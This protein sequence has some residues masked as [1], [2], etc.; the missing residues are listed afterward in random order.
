[1][2]IL[3]GLR[4][5]HRDRPRACPAGGIV[6]RHRPVLFHIL[7]DVCGRECSALL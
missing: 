6:E 5:W 3:I 4:Q 1:V 2:L 7:I